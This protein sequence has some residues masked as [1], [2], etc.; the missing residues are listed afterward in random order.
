M[1]NP[2]ATFL[3]TA[4]L[5]ALAADACAQSW[6]LLTPAPYP[7]TL[8]RR[9]GG[10]AFD[11]IQGKILIHGGLQS[12]PTLTLNDTWTFDGA[13]WT[14]L[15]P[16][17]TPPPR[18]GHRMVL[19]T[20][21][22]RIVTF[23]GRSPTT[24]ATANDTWEWDGSDWA[25]VFPAA[26]PNARAFYSMVFDERRG[27]C[28]LYG[29][30]SG[31]TFAG[32]DQTWE[33]DGTTWTQA[34]PTT[35]PPGLETP[36]MAYDKGRGVTVMFGGWNGTS[37]GTMYDRTYEYD[38][39]DWVRRSPATVPTARYD[40]ACVY[41]DG[42]GR[43]VLA[44]GYAGAAGG[45]QD[46]WEYDGNDWTQVLAA[47]GPPKVTG[48]YA[49]CSP[50]LQATMY[51]GGSGPAATGGS[52][53]ETW[54]YTGATDAIAAPFGTA[55]AT[56]TAL[57]S[58]VPATLPVLGGSYRLDLT[59]GTA[60]GI[61]F[62]THGFSNLFSPFGSLPYDLGAAGMPGCKLEVSSDASLLVVLTGGAASQLMALPNVPAA[63][64]LQLFSQG[65]VF[66]PATGNGRGGVSNAVH[67]VLGL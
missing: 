23:G 55:C 26:S 31:S 39:V 37:P 12:G 25:Q 27:V 46:T 11:P 50:L 56:S 35:V 51:F 61:G 28:V 47:G 65:F 22:L 64:G 16:A 49:A 54:L 1:A 2:S 67:A 15:A 58:L 19:D 9:S 43:V 29:T 18:W 44:G 33:Y 41:D 13:S 53:N 42:R 63:I 34:A 14:Q 5:L 60:S 3:S 32:G 52:A 24:T 48:G 57:P 17:T 7:T 4:V 66:D 30:Q 6:T 36:A 8:A 62:L 20:R 40:A 45:M 38:G 10:A 21:R 59:N